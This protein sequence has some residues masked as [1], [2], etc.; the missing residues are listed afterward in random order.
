MPPTR[1]TPTE[2]WVN[3]WGPCFEQLN[4]GVICYA[5]E[6]KDLCKQNQIKSSAFMEKT[7][8]KHD[9]LYSIW[10][11]G[12]AKRA[13]LNRGGPK[14]LSEDTMWNDWV[15]E[16]PWSQ[17]SGKQCWSGVR[18]GT[19]PRRCSG[20]YSGW[21][22]NMEVWRDAIIWSAFQQDALAAGLVELRRGKQSGSCD[23]IQV[24][25]M[26]GARSEPSSLVGTSLCFSVSQMSTTLHD[27]LIGKEKNKFLRSPTFVFGCIYH[28]IDSHNS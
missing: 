8:N 6:D 24:R 28:S 10:N 1:S 20:F 27:V 4:F 18:A 7:D 22:G 17:D 21:S 23:N 12:T 25:H 5:L 2:M 14:G 19:G 11:D 3:K 9:K 15:R 13:R 26:M 16:E